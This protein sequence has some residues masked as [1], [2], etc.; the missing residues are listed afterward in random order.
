MNGTRKLALGA[1]AMALTVGGAFAVSSASAEPAHTRQAAATTT[2]WAKI[3]AGGVL[4]GG[5]GVRGVTRFGTGRYNITTTS[6]LVGCAL[7]GT[8]NTNGGDDPGPG[9]ASILVG[10]L[11]PTT[12]FVRTATPSGTGNAVVDSDRPYSITAIC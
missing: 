5:Q 6:S 10:L 12:L 7:L 3:S 1:A 4:L 2:S 8:V 9:S 11:N